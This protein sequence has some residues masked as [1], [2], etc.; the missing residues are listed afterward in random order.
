MNRPSYAFGEPMRQD[1]GT[2]LVVSINGYCVGWID[3]YDYSQHCFKGCNVLFRPNLSHPT[4]ANKAM[5]Y[6]LWSPGAGSKV[7]ANSIGESKGQ[8]TK[9][10][11]P[12]LT[13]A[14][15]PCARQENS[16]APHPQCRK[17]SQ[18]EPLCS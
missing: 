7:S 12:R 10:N 18:D 8:D 11:K 16:R 2:S 14:V 4:A 13:Y 6:G 9:A 17:D 15:P 1:R 5:N 3:E